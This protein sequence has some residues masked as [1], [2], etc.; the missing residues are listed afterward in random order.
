MEKN[1]NRGAACPLLLTKYYSTDILKKKQMGWHITRTGLRCGRKVL[2]PKSEENRPLSR[3]IS[4]Y[5]NIKM[6]L[7]IVECVGMDW[8]DLAQDM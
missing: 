3:P 4:R 2:V 6:Y 5:D 8:I 7:Q 1:A